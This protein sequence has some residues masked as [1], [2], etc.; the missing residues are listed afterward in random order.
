MNRE[1]S[2][3]SQIAAKL[4]ELQG[5]LPCAICHQTP[6]LYTGVFIPNESSNKRIGS[7]KRKTRCVFYGLCEKCFQLPDKLKRIEQGLFYKFTVH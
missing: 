4:N 5:V 2:I 1:P 6:T 3:V 7:P